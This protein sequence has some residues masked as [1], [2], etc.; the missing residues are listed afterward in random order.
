[1]LTSTGW[2]KAVH[3]VCALHIECT[4]ALSLF[5]QQVKITSV[6]AESD[7]SASSLHPVFLMHS[8]YLRKWEDITHDPMSIV[9]LSSR[10]VDIATNHTGWL[11]A[12]SVHLDPV[13][14]ASMAMQA[15][16]VSPTTL[17]LHT[18]GQHFPDNIMQITVIMTPCKDSEDEVDSAYMGSIDH[19]PISFPHYLQAYPGEQLLCRLSG[20]FETD[21]S[22]G[23]TDLDFHFKATSGHSLMC[24][25]FVRLTLPSSQCHGGKLVVTRC[26]DGPGSDDIAHISL[27]LSGQKNRHSRGE[28]T[29]GRPQV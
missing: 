18:F 29:T 16:S 27:H 4:P 17:Q 28:F 15:L 22:S 13:H 14:I 24:G 12:A 19:T 8:R 26:A 21:V 23:E 11:A 2:D 5:Q 10:R 9:S 20:P 1:M 6:L 3:I 7:F 25:K